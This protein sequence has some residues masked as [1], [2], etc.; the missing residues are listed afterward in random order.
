MIVKLDDF[1]LRFVALFLD[2]SETVVR[3]SVRALT[4]LR[5]DFTIWESSVGQIRN[6]SA[7]KEFSA[8]HALLVQAH[9]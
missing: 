7:V 5:T 3:P 1:D 6:V 8:C 9:S 4:S 2:P